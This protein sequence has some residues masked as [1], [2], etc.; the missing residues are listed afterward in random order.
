MTSAKKPATGQI[1]QKAEAMIAELHR[2]GLTE[3]AIQYRLRKEL[4]EKVTLRTI[5]RRKARLEAEIGTKKLFK[6]KGADIVQKFLDTVKEGK[7]VG[8]LQ[9][10]LEQAV[11]FDCLRRYAA[12]EDGFLKDVNPKDLLK[13]T[14]D[15]QKARLRQASSP[16]SS[17][18]TRFAFSPAHAIELLQVVE[19]SLSDSPELKD[20]F[21]QR[22]AGVMKKIKPM[23]DRGEFESATEDFEQMQKIREKY[24]Q[25]KSDNGIRKRDNSRATA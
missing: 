12:D 23:F 15:Y 13:I 17:N 22:R 9:A 3:R 20:A 24:E 21:A 6:Q 16:N 18:G 11:Y 19:E 8:D 5:A 2:S 1:S 14:H 10:V 7:D 4:E 25:S